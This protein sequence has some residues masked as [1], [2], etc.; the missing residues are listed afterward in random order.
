MAE[1]LHAGTVAATFCHTF[2]A[3]PRQS[4]TAGAAHG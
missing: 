1:L 3:L 4:S 2:A